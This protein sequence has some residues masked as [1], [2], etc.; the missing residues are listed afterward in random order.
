MAG[1]VED[2]YIGRKSFAILVRTP[3][4]NAIAFASFPQRGQ[5]QEFA[6]SLIKQGKRAFVRRDPR[7][8]EETIGDA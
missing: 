5:A 6:A 4:G 7:L 2:A 3:S 1:R 8:D